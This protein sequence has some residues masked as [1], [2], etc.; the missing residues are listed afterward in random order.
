MSLLFH[1]AYIEKTIS[2]IGCNGRDRA[3]KLFF[4]PTHVVEQ[5]LFSIVLSILT[6]DLD[7]LLGSFL[8]FWGAN[9]TYLGLR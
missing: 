1:A 9:G 6:F 7:L 2:C 3:Q 5:L 4:G 8:T